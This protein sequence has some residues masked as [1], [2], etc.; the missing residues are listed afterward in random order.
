MINF[1][2]WL[3]LGGI[4]GWIASKIMGTDAQ[5]GPFL[6]VVVGI[7][8]SMLAGFLLSPLFHE[9]TINQGDFSLGGL[10]MSLLG[11]VI[12]LAIVNW[13]RRGRT[14]RARM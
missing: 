4:I 5:Q 6:N 14:H 7:I 11:S 9:G 8:G 2:L 13:F 1:I 3:I 12:L 10:L